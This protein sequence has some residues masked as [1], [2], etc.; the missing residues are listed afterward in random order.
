MA[1]RVWECSSQGKLFLGPDVAEL[2]AAKV[3][4]ETRLNLVAPK[5]KNP[6]SPPSFFSGSAIF[7]RRER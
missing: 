6:S 5:F 1:V 7:L 3:L 2:T 4:P